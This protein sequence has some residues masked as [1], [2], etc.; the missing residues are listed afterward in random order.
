MKQ[1]EKKPSNKISYKEYAQAFLSYLKRPKTIFDI[2]DRAKAAFLI[3]LVIVALQMLVE[4]L[5]N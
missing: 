2:K 3:G 5:I 1:D 4:K